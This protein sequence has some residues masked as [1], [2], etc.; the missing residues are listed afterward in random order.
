MN[1]E[2]ERDV[3]LTNSLHKFFI[4]K[5]TFL[6]SSRELTIIGYIFL[7]L[8]NHNNLVKALWRIHVKRHITISD[9]SWL[10]NIRID[11]NLPILLMIEMS[12]WRVF[13]IPTC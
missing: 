6:I 2:Y 12:N 9:R 13:Q 5:N 3:L 4:L 11:K 10:S 1:L 7:V 8:D